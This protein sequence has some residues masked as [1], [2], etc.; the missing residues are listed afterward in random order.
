MNSTE[1]KKE[2]ASENGMESIK[3]IDVVKLGCK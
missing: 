3:R 2:T 1:E